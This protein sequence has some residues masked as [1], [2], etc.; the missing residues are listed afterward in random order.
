MTGRRRPAL[1]SCARDARAPT[2]ARPWTSPARPELPVTAILVAI[3]EEPDPS[4]LPEGAGIGVSGWA[5]IVAD[6]GP[7]HRPGR[8]VRRRRRRL[9]AQTIIDAVAAGRRAA[10]PSTNT[11]PAPRTAK[12]RSWRQCAT[13]RRP[14]PPHARHRRA[15]RAHPALPVVD[16]GRSPPPSGLRRG[17]RARRGVPL[18]PLRRC[19]RLRRVQVVA[20][21][22]H[23]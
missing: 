4:I 12:R 9:R 3:G 2:A 19:L 15:A 16:T 8:G 7:W 5:G 6:P 1:E 11:S 20:G 23:R 17:R 10:G 14:S 13:R 21:A 18:L 22:A